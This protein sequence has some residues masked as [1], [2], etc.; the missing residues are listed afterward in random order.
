MFL[1]AQVKWELDPVIEKIV[2][3]WPG[4]VDAPFA[5]SLGFH[6]DRYVSPINSR[7]NQ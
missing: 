7:R 5:K 4:F 2:Y 1:Y 6:V 3:S